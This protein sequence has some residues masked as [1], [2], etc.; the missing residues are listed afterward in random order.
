MCRF[1]YGPKFLTHLGNEV[2]ECNCW[3]YGEDTFRFF[4]ELPNGLYQFTFPAAVNESSGSSTPSLVS[5]VVGDLHPGTS[6]R[7]ASLFTLTVF[8]SVTVH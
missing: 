8:K 4:K 6:N 3:I 1:L 2:K 5:G 7:R